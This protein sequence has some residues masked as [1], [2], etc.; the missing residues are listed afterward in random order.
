[1][2]EIAVKIDAAIRANQFQA[3]EVFPDCGELAAKF[4]GT[5]EQIQYGIGDLIYEG[6]L[7]RVPADPDRVRIRAG[8]LWDVVRGNHSFTG[9]AKKRG[10]KPGNRILTFETRKVW[11]Q[12]IQRLSLE[13]GEEVL[14][15]ERLLLADDK[16]VGLEFSY[17]PAR[18]YEG[19]TREMFEGGHS[20][21]AVMEEKGLIPDTAIDE[22]SVATL[23]KREAELLG[24]EPG[25]PVLIRFRVTLSPAGI[26]IKGSRA[27]YLFRPGYQLK[28]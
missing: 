16:P 3:D 20:T 8:Y 14:V 27:I 28:I 23:E 4:G 11:P 19:A 9:E 15:M 21:F 2:N 22:I 18:Y 25:V 26:P 10:Q 7:E 1:M 5:V 6:V 13:E 17:M 24:L 12:I